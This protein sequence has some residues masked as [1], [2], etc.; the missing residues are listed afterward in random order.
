MSLLPLSL[1]LL[2][3]VAL[4]QGTDECGKRFFENDYP[5]PKQSESAGYI[6]GGHTAKKGAHPWQ[7]SIQWI[8][9]FC[10]GTIIDKRWILTASHCFTEDSN[11]VKIVAGEHN[12]MVNEGTE[13]SIYVKNYFM[14]PQFSSYTF[15]N[16][17]ALLELEDDLIFNEYVQPA[18][19]PKLANEKED[20]EAGSEVTISGWGSTIGHE[21][22]VDPPLNKPEELQVAT[23]ALISDKTC[24]KPQY[25][26]LTHFSKS[27]MCAGRLGV[28]GVD[29]CK[30]DSG[31]PLVKQ[32]DEKWTVLGVISWGHGCAQPNKPG[33][34]T[35][36]ARFEKW[37]SETMAGV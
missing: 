4:V 36:V 8:G 17:I 27:M 34:Y 26:G 7:V 28:G 12:L 25:H 18:C 24:R 2:L 14:H 33:V 19:L 35:R 31:G 10:G 9:H 32:I 3:A 13:Q 15:N 29:S 11:T 20:Y 22:S 6:V 16:D 37:I 21:I 1:A 23:V 30:G 5:N